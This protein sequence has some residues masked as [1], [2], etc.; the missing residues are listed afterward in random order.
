M[1]GLRSPLHVVTSLTMLGL[2]LFVV[3]TARAQTPNVPVDKPIV[4]VNKT[5]EATEAKP[6]D[7]ATNTDATAKSEVTTNAAPAP[8]ATPTPTPTP[9]PC[10]AGTRTIKADVVA[11][12]QP[13]M[14]NRL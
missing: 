9:P 14:L 11:I 6:S 4:E 12:P 1:L 8:Q 10:P 2:S 13:I 3:T 5:S 7:P